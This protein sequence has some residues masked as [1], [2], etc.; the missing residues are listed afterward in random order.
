M[1]KKIIIGISLLFSSFTYAEVSNTNKFAALAVDRNDGF[2]YGFSYD[3]PQSTV[4]EKKALEEC[5]TRSK[6]NNCSV[7]LSWSGKGC[8]AYRT[9]DKSAGNAYGWGLASTKEQ[10]DTIAKNELMKRSNGNNIDSNFSW[11]CN[12]KDNR[13]LKTIKN[14]AKETTQTASKTKTPSQVKT[15]TIG[16]QVWMAENLSTKKFQNGDDIQAVQTHSDYNLN[17]KRRK[18]TTPLI[19]LKNNQVYYNWY[20]ASDTRKICPVGFRI[21]LKDD[22]TL[23]I[24]NVYKNGYTLSH[25]AVDQGKTEEDIL[26]KLKS[27]TGWKDVWNNATGEF[28]FNMKPS[29]ELLAAYT[30]SKVVDTTEK[31]NS[32]AFIVPIVNPDDPDTGMQFHVFGSSIQYMNVYKYMMGSIRCLKE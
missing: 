29:G 8:G 3:H 26:S 20:A 14:L 6:N 32:T 23:L 2:A 7:V 27:K 30:D 21:P 24:N 11:A 13:P 9:V 5:N 22:W 25:S 16:N 31:Q 10:A 28:N 15:I 18:D 17:G 1:E 4:A 12:S 19:Y